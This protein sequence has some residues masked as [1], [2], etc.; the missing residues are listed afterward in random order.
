MVRHHGSAGA[1]LYEEGPRCM[2]EGGDR[3][4]GARKGG[5]QM[6]EDLGLRP[7][8]GRQHRRLAAPR[9]RRADLALGQVEAFPDAL[10]GSVTAMAAG[11]DGSS[12]AAGHCVF[13]ET[14]Q[15]AGGQAQPPDFVGEP[16]AEGPPAAGPGLAVAAKDAAGADRLFPGAA[17]IVSAQRTVANQRADHLAVRTGHQLEPLTNRVP[18]VG[19]AV[20]PMLLGHARTAPP[21]KSRFYR[22]QAVR[23]RGEVR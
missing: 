12:N 21:R 15:T 7:R 23:G 16:D 6:G 18:V 5:L 20:K 9:Q 17:F 1:G 19:A 10:P 2:L 22:R 13:E 11:P 4:V 8:F 3:T 14:P